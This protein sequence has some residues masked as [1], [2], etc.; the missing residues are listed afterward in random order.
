[1]IKRFDGSNYIDVENLRR[2]DGAN[3]IDTEKNYRFDGVNWI[4]F[5]SRTPKFSVDIEQNVNPLWGEGMYTLLSPNRIR[6]N[7]GGTGSYNASCFVTFR[8]KDI[9]IP[10]SVTSYHNYT[11]MGVGS[12]YD[13][14]VGIAQTNGGT[15]NTFYYAT[16]ISSTDT[17]A[18]MEVSYNNA[19]ECNPAFKFETKYS[20]GARIEVQLNSIIVNGKTYYPEFKL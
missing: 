13:L 11:L 10:A 8:C 15:K 12:T 4:E 6:I 20:I 16:G 5:Y 17:P 14:G 19:Y 18:N 7:I 1:M 9:I 2:Y 3:W